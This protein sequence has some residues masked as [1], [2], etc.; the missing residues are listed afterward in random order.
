MSPDNDEILEVLKEVR[1]ILSRIYVCF[2]D[3]YLKIQRQKL[4]EKLEAFEALLT[5][6]RR[7]IYPL[8][9]DS[10][11]L[12]QAEIANEAHIAQS[13]VSKF[14]SA[15]LDQELIE[16]VKHEDGSVTYRDRYDLVKLMQD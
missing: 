1:D 13:T 16:Q 15:L 3:D 10:R 6:A 2:E 11:R 8:L 4:V 7:D 12:S 14:I 9:F 5:P